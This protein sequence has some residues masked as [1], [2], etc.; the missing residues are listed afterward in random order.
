MAMDKAGGLERQTAT[1]NGT[2]FR[3]EDWLEPAKKFVKD[4]AID[5]VESFV[6]EH[7]TELAI[8]VAGTAA[9]F[10]AS[11]FGLG[12]AVARTLGVDLEEV[13]AGLGYKPWRS[14]RTYIFDIDR[15]LVDTDKAFGIYK[16]TLRDELLARSGLAAD[17]L[18]DGIAG[19]QK[20][21]KTDF[22]GEGL[23]HIEPLAK[24]FPGQD[25]NVL[26]RAANE[27]AK[28]A[29]AS[30]LQPRADVLQALD[31]LKT[32]NRRLVTYTGGS[33]AHTVEKLDM[34]GLSKYFDRIYTS[35]KHPWEDL[36]RTRA[37]LP[38]TTWDRLVE[39]SP[40]AKATPK[41]FEEIAAHEGTKLRTVMV[42]DHIKEDM[43]HAQQSGF[44]AAQATWFRR[45]LEDGINADFMLKEPR[46]I[47]KINLARRASA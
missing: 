30:A 36:V 42:G 37:N 29:Y 47:L 3:S 19:A 32:G 2:T 12:G 20:V 26:F 28:A 38:S 24:A 5:P 10:A 11:R 44:K 45:Q 27:N 15:T 46:D 40:S 22:I 39:L 31:T 25:V 23:Q 35:G 9:V 6:G 1:D 16:S 33:P 7:A 43:L 14:A 4:Y 34:A 17:V 41:G 13:G 18:D 8:G 21:L